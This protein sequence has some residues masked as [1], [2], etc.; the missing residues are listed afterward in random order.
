MS[1]F[2]ILHNNN[3]NNGNIFLKAQVKKGRFDKLQNS[4]SKKNIFKESNK[5]K[6]KE[7]NTKKTN[8]RCDFYYDKEKKTENQITV[9][10]DKSNFP[11]LNINNREKPEL[12]NKCINYKDI[13]KKKANTYCLKRNEKPLLL[14]PLCSEDAVTLRNDL[15]KI[16]IEIENIYCK[17]ITNYWKKIQMRDREQRIEDGEFL[18]EYNDNDEYLY[19]SDNDSD[20]EFNCNYNDF[21]D[22][23]N[24]Y[25]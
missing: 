4:N 18:Y 22:N 19:T 16:N 24:Y 14:L 17:N 13:T 5:P 21:Y 8:K 25:D 20:E 12:N 1:R 3:N 7:N 15:D 23:D 6:N 11:E 10:I 9:T 2:N